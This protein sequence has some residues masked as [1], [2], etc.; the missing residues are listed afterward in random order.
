[1]KLSKEEMSWVLVDCG[2]FHLHHFL[3]GGNL[4]HFSRACFYSW[5]D[6]R[7][8]ARRNSGIKSVLLW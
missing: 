3:R 5:R 8:G 2:N 4:Y 7:L 1:M 6:D